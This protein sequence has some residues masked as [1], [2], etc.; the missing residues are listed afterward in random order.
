M[1]RQKGQEQTDMTNFSS[2]SYTKFPKH[3]FARFRM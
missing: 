2:D 1:Y 3:R